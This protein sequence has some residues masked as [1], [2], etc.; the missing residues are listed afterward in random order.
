M[1]YPILFLAVFLV[2]GWLITGI[3]RR[4]G[5]RVLL[6]L[7]FSYSLAALNVLLMATLNVPPSFFIPLLTVEIAALLLIAV[8]RWRRKLRPLRSCR[9]HWE[10][11]W[12]GLLTLTAAAVYLLWAGPY[13][14][15]PADAWEHL[16]R[17]QVQSE[18]LRNND[19]GL[20]N[21]WRIWVSQGHV[22]Y[23]LQAALCRWS[24]LKVMDAVPHMVLMNSLA[25]IAGIY[26]FGVKLFAPMRSK[27]WV[28]ALAAALAALFYTIFFGVNVFAYVRYY[29]LAPTMPSFTIYLA[30]MVFVMDLL[31]RDTWQWCLIWPPSLFFLVLNVMHTQEALFVFFMAWGISIV[32]TVRCRAMGVQAWRRPAGILCLAALSAWLGLFIL[33]HCRPLSPFWA[34]GAVP[35]ENVLPFLRGML[36]Q[37]PTV[38]FYPVIAMWGLWVYLLFARHWREFTCLPLIMAGMA[39][40]LLTVFNPVSIDFMLRYMPDP[41]AL[42]RFNYMLPLPYVAAWFAVR[43]APWARGALR[44]ESRLFSFIIWVG[45]FFWLLPWHG[46]Y[47]N[48]TYSRLPTLRRVNPENDWRYW[49]DLLEEIQTHPESAI[50]T[51]HVT[52]YMWRGATQHKI[53]SQRFDD[54]AFSW[55]L[56]P[57]EAEPGLDELWDYLAQNERRWLLVVNLRD[58]AMSEVGRLSGH[59]PADIL[60]V[61]QYYDPHTLDWVAQR[62]DMFRLLWELNRIQ[63]YEVV[64]PDKLLGEVEDLPTFGYEDLLFR[65]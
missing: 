62:P 39:M 42:Y 35:I 43:G 55:W 2:P 1:L 19:F 44:R 58:G 3:M 36:V 45:L 31:R 48:S 37:S 30:A 26:L 17:L 24:G 5:P 8:W 11:I 27:R 14:E 53:C 22:W 56:C 41:A 47:F 29:A 40:P 23:F 16:Y 50:I 49:R 6:A 38:H 46:E 4:R 12:A 59:W 28:K 10:F 60:Q 18:A 51:D 65:N 9:L 13:L 52:G 32:E 57:E 21:K 33:S 7:G 54:T 64:C 15:I 34:R 25:W 20:E 63:I 61:S